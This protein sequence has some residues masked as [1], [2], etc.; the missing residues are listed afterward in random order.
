MRDQLWWIEKPNKQLVTYGR[1]I[2]RDG[3]YEGGSPNPFWTRRDATAHCRD[4]EKPVKVKIIK[5]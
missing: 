1:T 2:Y 3:I 4:G 5:I